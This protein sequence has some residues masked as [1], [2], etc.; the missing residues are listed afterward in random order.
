MKLFNEALFLIRLKMVIAPITRVGKAALAGLTSEKY[1]KN[2]GECE[3]ENR[4]ARLDAF[5]PRFEF[6]HGQTAKQTA[7]DSRLAQYRISVD[8]EPRDGDQWYKTQGS[9]GAGH[10]ATVLL[11]PGRILLAENTSVSKRFRDARFLRTKNEWGTP[12]VVFRFPS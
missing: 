1:P 5:G 11:I 12:D 6:T 4:M 2:A 9:G 3:R 7:E 8:S 10:A